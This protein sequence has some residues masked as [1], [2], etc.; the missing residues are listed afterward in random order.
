MVSEHT[1]LVPRRYMATLGKGDYMCRS[2]MFRA[3]WAVALTSTIAIGQSSKRH[4]FDVGPEVYYFYYQE[5]QPV[6]FFGREFPD[7]VVMEQDG[8]FYGVGGAYTFRGWVSSSAEKVSG[9]DNGLMLRTEG[10]FAVGNVDYDGQTQ[11][12]E[13]LTVTDIDDHTMELRPLIGLGSESETGEW[14][15]YTGFGYRYLNDDLSKFAGGYERES[16]YYYIPIGFW[17]QGPA[18]ND[19]TTR[20]TLEGD[21]L[22]R[23]LQRSH[24]SDLDLGLEDVENEQRGGWA[25]RTSYRFERTGDIGLVLEPFFRVWLIN[26][27]EVE[28][29]SGGIPVYEPKNATIEGGVSLLIRF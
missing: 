16:N 2:F 4:S 14:V 29:I 13:P 7:E 10:R 19:W 25:F 24:L 15:L 26:K 6:E 23:G 8:L 12:G 11:A 5:T 1:I 3:V 17:M 28:T 22:V 21:I 9:A 27:S 18:S 20:W